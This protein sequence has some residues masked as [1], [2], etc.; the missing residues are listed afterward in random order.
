[1]EEAL[2]D[3]SWVTAIHDE[4]HQF[5]RNDVWTLVS[6]PSDQNIISTKWIFKNKSDEH[7]MVIRNKA[8]L[9]AQGYTQIEGID[10]HETFSPVVCLESI[11]ILLSISCHLGFKLYQMD[12]K[13]AFLNGILQEVYVE[14]PKGF[15]DPHYPHHVYKL[16]KDLYG[17]K[18]APRAWY[19]RL[20]TYLLEKWFTRGQADWTFF[21]RNQ[22]NHKLIAQIYVDDIIFGATLD[23]QAHEFAE[24]MKQEFEMSMIGEL[25]YFLGMQVKQTGEGIFIS[26][27][28]YAKDLVKRLGLDGKSHARTPL[29]TNVK[30]SADPTSKQ[31]D[32]TLYRSMIGSF[33]YLTASPPDIAFSVGVCTRFQA[34][35]KESHIT[36]V[37]RIIKYVNATVNY[38]IYFSRE[39]NLVLAGY[40]DADWAGNADDRKSTSGGCFYVGTNLV[41]WMSRKQASIS[42]STAEAEYIAAGS[43]CTQLLWMKKLLCDYGFTQDTM[44]IHCDNTSA[45]NISKNP[46]QYSRT[47]HIDIR[48]HF[49]RDLVES[50]EVALMFIPTENQLSDILTKPLDGSRFE[51]LRK[52]IGICDMS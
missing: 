38:G 51:S 9:V 23:S 14:Q 42:L 20:T 8:Q 7:G 1:V 21:I 18:Q 11:R 48:H 47:K 4:L 16:K 27:A 36:A 31:V 46:V 29:S 3:D 22:G 49:I 43:C 10:F 6:R 15:L 45:I 25:T 28:K 24:E 50:R 26:Q 12:V 40:S 34:N 2:Q 17:L 5:S 39:T 37:K 13:S 35:P 32:P 30:I 44:V 41:A 33:L 52:A 19:E